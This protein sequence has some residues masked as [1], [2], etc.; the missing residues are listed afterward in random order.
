[1]AR[2]RSGDVNSARPLLK[3]AAIVVLKNP[4]DFKGGVLGESESKTKAILAAS[5]GKVL[6]MDEARRALHSVITVCSSFDVF[7]RTLSTARQ[8]A[9]RR[10]SI[11]T[12][13]PSSTLLW[14]RYRACPERTDASSCAAMRLP[15]ARCSKC[16][17]RVPALTVELTN[18]WL[19]RQPWAVASFPYRRWLL[20]PRLRRR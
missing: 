2:V 3:L 6:V 15:C 14:P 4:A 20:F 16:V 19:E 1:M 18:V 10:R 7:R 13:P 12:A 8:A 5:L 11:P 17:S 9:A